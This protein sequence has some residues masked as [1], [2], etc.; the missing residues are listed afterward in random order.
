MPSSSVIKFLAVL[1]KLVRSLA[2]SYARHHPTLKA[3]K[4]SLKDINDEDAIALAE[5]W[6]VELGTPEAVEA[7]ANKN[8]AW[9]EAPAAVLVE[10]SLD[11][12]W[13]N[14]KFKAKSKRYTW[15][16][17]EQLKLHADAVASG[18]DSDGEL[19]DPDEEENGGM[20]GLGGLAKFASILPKSVLDKMAEKMVK[21]K[22]SGKEP[23]N[24]EEAIKMAM[25]T[26]E[27]DD[28]CE[29][30]MQLT[31]GMEDESMKN[32][33][34]FKNLAARMQKAGE[35]AQQRED[36]REQKEVGGPR[37]AANFAA[38]RARMDALEKERV[39]V[40]REMVA[41]EADMARKR[42]MLAARADSAPVS[43]PVGPKFVS[44]HEEKKED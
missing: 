42:E 18:D 15:T 26:F 4:K 23:A 35:E 24:A 1:R 22:R 41:Y 27:I 30:A 5:R 31:K 25:K 29:V 34:E 10:I 28:V 3:Y 33:P 19:E 12:I 11:L 40:D 17:L 16:Y 37:E 36:A 38:M 44:V 13:K 2:K 9:F 32:S 7:L 6:S 39:A 20:G 14:K 43:V 8:A 21:M